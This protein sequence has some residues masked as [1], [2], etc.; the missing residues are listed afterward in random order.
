MAEQDEWKLGDE[1][2]SAA[3]LCPACGHS[4]R[5]GLTRCRACG[6]SLAAEEH[7]EPTP[8]RTLG[9]AM[10]GGRAPRRGARRGAMRWR[11]P[12]A[13]LIIAVVAAARYLSTTSPERHLTL[14]REMLSP[15]GAPSPDTLGGRPRAGATAAPVSPPSVGAANAR[16]GPEATRPD[17]AERRAAPPPAPSA[18]ATPLNAEAAV[19]RRPPIAAPPVERTPPPVVPRKPPAEPPARA[20]VVPPPARAPEPTPGRAAIPPPARAPEPAISPR[21]PE[22]A[23][24]LPPP[25]PPRPQELEERPSLGSDLVDARRAYANAIQAY[26]ARADDYNALADEFQ[27]RESAGDPGIGVLRDRLERARVA[28]DA[29]REQADVLRQNM[30]AVQGR[31]R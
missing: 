8:L 5:A 13:A 29:A 20:A 19:E 1:P 15:A 6:A 10:A 27:R 25:P 11:W 31:Y 28:A 7:S 9:E 26:N 21:A 16:R 23:A 2:G 18:R 14:D 4:N 12:A 24:A 17:A 3:D 30:E 22:R